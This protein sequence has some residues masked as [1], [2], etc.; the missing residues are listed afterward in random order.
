MTAGSAHIADNP[1]GAAAN[2]AAAT[3]RAAV[4]DRAGAA[5]RF[6]G[7]DTRLYLVTD[8]TPAILGDRDLDSVVAAAVKGGVTCVQY[9]NK[10]K[11]TGDLV[12][13]A[14]KLHEVTRAHGLPLL[15]NDRVDVALAVG[16]EGVHIGQD[17]M[18][19]LR[20]P[21]YSCYDVLNENVHETVRLICEQT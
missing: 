10:T 14:K 6:A 13:E 16:C 7:I 19:E 20:N 15:I 9:R 8:S 4:T 21:F 1:N 12:A 11:D 5:D 17:D 2:G 3:D 18:G